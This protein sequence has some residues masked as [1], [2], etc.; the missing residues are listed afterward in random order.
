MA[1]HAPAVIPCPAT[2]RQGAGR[3]DA[4]RRGAGRRVAVAKVAIAKVGVPKRAAAKAGVAKSIVPNGV[5]VMAGRRAR[6]TV[7]T[8]L[9]FGLVAGFRRDRYSPDPSSAILT[10]HDQR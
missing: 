8:E 9:P 3:Q 2:G 4:R 1:S 10:F 7:W 5:V 6:V